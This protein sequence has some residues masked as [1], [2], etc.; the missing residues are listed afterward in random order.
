MESQDLRNLFF[1]KANAHGVRND[2]YTPVAFTSA[3]VFDYK[4]E[5]EKGTAFYGKFQTYYVI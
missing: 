1:K 3:F 2:V 5:S 4:L